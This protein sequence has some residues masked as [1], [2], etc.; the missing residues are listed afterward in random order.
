ML[1]YIMQLQN[2][3]NS[4]LYVTNTHGTVQRARHVNVKHI[5]YIV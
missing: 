4:N 3:L 5:L 2:N 1:S